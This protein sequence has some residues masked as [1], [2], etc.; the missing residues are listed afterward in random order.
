[1]QGHV[2]DVVMQNQTI[3]GASTL[4]IVRC[5]TAITSRASIIE[6]LRMWC[7]QE[8]NETSEQLGIQWGQKASAFGTYTSTTPAPH[9]I[10][11]NASGI[12][13]G[14][15]GAAAT[16]GTDASAEGA[17]TFTVLGEEPFNNL[18]GW[19]WIATEKE[20]IIV[21]PDTAFALK[22]PTA[23]T[24]TNNWTAGITFAEIN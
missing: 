9:I 13:G 8:G 15:S 3:A 2:Y 12:A 17:G 24:N 5:A 1:M 23:P 14:T 10:G 11:G 6:I 19:A 16:S 4:V 7:G 20:R 22:L 21:P 18:N